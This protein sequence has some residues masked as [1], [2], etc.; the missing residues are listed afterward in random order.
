[1]TKLR[2]GVIPE[3]KPVKLTLEIP[4]EMMRE[5]QDYAEVHA[6]LT[7]LAAP[8]PI[9]RIVPAMIGR[10]IAGDR[11]PYMLWAFLESDR[12]FSKQR[13]RS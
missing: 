3:D 9:E 5:L 1:M 7:G 12:E 10:F 13:R 8:L 2:L 4:G 6:R 11:I